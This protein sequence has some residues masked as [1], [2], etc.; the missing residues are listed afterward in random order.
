LLRRRSL[1][2]YAL[3]ITAIL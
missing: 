3:S 1:F 2:I